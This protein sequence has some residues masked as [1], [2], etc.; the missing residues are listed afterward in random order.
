MTIKKLLVVLALASFAAAIVRK[1][2]SS[3]SDGLS[4]PGKAASP[5]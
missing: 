3:E 4:A 1:K 2:R 5:A